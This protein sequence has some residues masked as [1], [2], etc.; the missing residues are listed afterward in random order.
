MIY[1]MLRKEFFGHI[2]HVYWFKALQI[3]V[4]PAIDSFFQF[5]A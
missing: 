1:L 5:I 3:F 2:T 4:F